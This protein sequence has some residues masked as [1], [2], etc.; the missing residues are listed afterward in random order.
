MSI[1]NESDCDSSLDRARAFRHL[2]GNDRQ[3]C[4]FFIVAMK[5]MSLSY[6]RSSANSPLVGGL[7]LPG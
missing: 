3:R 1:R 4:G 7:W 2:A 6:R 5:T